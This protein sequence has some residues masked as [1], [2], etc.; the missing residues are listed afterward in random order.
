MEFQ[1]EAQRLI[2][3]IASFCT[4][5][6][7]KESSYWSTVVH[8]AVK[9][10][11][12]DKQT[13]TIRALGFVKQRVERGEPLIVPWGRGTTINPAFSPRQVIHGEVKPTMRD[14][15]M[16]APFLGADVYESELRGRPFTFD[17]FESTVKAIAA[18]IRETE[19]GNVK[20][21]RRC[22]EDTWVRYMLHHAANN[23]KYQTTKGHVKPHVRKN[24]LN[25]AERVRNWEMLY[26]PIDLFSQKELP[27]IGNEAPMNWLRVPTSDVETSRALGRIGIRRAQMV[28]YRGTQAEVDGGLLF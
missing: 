18:K 5:R 28:G 7:D 6:G 20:S 8:N 11:P 26:D 19:L 14:E 13:S 2:N 22:R 23:P 9:T 24:L 4:N 3:S 25:L 17:L 1:S 10:C 21:K 15:P 27:P 16:C 12:E